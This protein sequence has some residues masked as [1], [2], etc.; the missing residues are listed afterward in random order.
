MARTQRLRFALDAAY[1]GIV[2]DTEALLAAVF[3]DNSAGRVLAHEGRMVV[4]WVYSQHLRCLFPQHGMGKKHE[5]P[6]LLEPWQHEL[7]TAA[8]WDFLRGCI[9]SDGCVFIN[10]TGPYEYLSYDFANLSRDILDL[11]VGT[12]ARLGLRPRRYAKRV[13]LY[14]REDVARLVEN[15]GIK[16]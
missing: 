13:R 1:P 4:L 10:R 11:F 3:P 16:S 9:R 14:R 6:I 15:V 7:V 12:C 8:P 5:R 2:A